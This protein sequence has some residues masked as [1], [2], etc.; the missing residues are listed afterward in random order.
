[1]R[2]RQQPHVERVIVTRHGP[3]LT[4]LLGDAKLPPLAVRWV[5]S[6][7]GGFLRSAL[8]LNRAATMEEAVDALRAW[9]APSQ[10]VVLA[11]VRGALA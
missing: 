5:G 9:S 3:L 7:G 10:S 8:Q 4:G 6:E 11:D 1:V 2:G